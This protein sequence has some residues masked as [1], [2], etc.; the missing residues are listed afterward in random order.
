M[1]LLNPAGRWQMARLS[2]LGGARYGESTEEGFLNFVSLILLLVNG[3]QLRH[4]R[5]YSLNAMQLQLRCG[6]AHAILHYA[7]LRSPDST[8]VHRGENSG[9]YAAVQLFSVHLAP[10]HATKIGT[11]ISLDVLIPRPNSARR[12]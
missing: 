10:H 9:F 6:P 11:I 4:E 7:E 1:D 2:R 12:S 5:R 3:V 8:Q